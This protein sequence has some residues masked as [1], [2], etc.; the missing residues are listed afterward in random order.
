MPKK[1]KPSKTPLPNDIQEA[2]LSLPLEISGEVQSVGEVLSQVRS[3]LKS[4]DEGVSEN[5]L[6]R[7]IAR[8]LMREMKRRGNPS[9]RISP[10]GEPFLFIDYGLAEEREPLPSLEELREQ[11]SL[12][13]VDI[14]DLGRKKIEIL[15]RLR[16]LERASLADDRSEGFLPPKIKLPR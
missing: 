4:V 15:K 6:L 16:D 10:A 1:L 7:Y 9:I 5:P 11:A 3:L 2:V 13:G 12:Q 8:N 14:S